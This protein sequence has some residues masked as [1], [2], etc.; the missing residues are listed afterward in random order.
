MARKRTRRV[1]RRRSFLC[2]MARER[3]SSVVG[4]EDGSGVWEV[5]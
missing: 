2:G 1:C 5:S 3:T 4:L